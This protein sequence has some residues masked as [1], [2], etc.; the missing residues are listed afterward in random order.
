MVRVF[1]ES[2]LFNAWE[3]TKYTPWF[4]LGL[5]FSTFLIS[6]TGKACKWK[7]DKNLVYFENQLKKISS[8][9]FCQKW[10]ALLFQA[11]Q[12]SFFQCYVNTKRKKNCRNYLKYKFD[13]P[14]LT[15]GNTCFHLPK[16]WT[17]VLKTL[18]N[19][20]SFNHST[21]KWSLLKNESNFKIKKTWANTNVNVTNVRN[22]KKW[23][24]VNNDSHQSQ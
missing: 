24:K 19:F 16:P 10:I 6:V 4:N 2:S 5:R 1:A 23:C 14:C 21:W 18:N 17:R 11:I 7:L 13:F 9:F 22:T 20:P 8:Y 3:W 15:L 12:M